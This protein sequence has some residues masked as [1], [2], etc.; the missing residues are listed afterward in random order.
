MNVTKFIKLMVTKLFWLKVGEDMLVTLFECWCLALMKSDSGCW[1]PK[2]QNRHQHHLVVTSILHLQHPS[3]TS[4]NP[5]STGH[6]ILRHSTRTTP[7]YQISE[8]QVYIIRYYLKV[9]STVRGY[10][11]EII[12]QFFW[13]FLCVFDVFIY[14]NFTK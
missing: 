2:C 14:I 7:L 13:V 8:Y 12:S 3:R 6:H 10:L 9:N 4:W 1:R 5:L 11:L